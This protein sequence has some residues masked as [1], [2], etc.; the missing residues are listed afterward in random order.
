[1][2][3]SKS[4]AWSCL[5][6]T[7][8]ELAKVKVGAVCRASYINTLHHAREPE[9]RTF[10]VLYAKLIAECIYESQCRCLQL[11]DRHSN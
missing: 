1:M 8:E 10:T 7:G 5:E 2:L 11:T 4:D 9:Q 3:S 6:T